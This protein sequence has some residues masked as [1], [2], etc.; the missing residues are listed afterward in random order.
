MLVCISVC[1]CVSLCVLVCVCDSV[2]IGDDGEGDVNMQL[3][4]RLKTFGFFGSL[5][6]KDTHTHTQSKKT[7]KGVVRVSSRAQTRHHW[8]CGLLFQSWGLFCHTGTTVAGNVPA[9]WFA[10]H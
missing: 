6:P 2:G 8:G 4:I 3:A 5:N 9:V 7:T 1:V 10:C